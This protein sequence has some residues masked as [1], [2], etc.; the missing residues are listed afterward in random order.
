MMSALGHPRESYFPFN[1][2]S[3]VVTFYCRILLPKK[4]NRKTEEGLEEQ[5]L[6]GVGE[7]PSH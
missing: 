5:A 3:G 7:I 2:L 4:K 6:A 1:F